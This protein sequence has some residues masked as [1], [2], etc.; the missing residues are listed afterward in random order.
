MR[1]RSSPC[2]PVISASAM[3]TAITPTITPSTEISEISEMNA[4]LRFAQQVAERDEQLERQ[5]L[6]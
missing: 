6:D 2:R 5:D 4:C 1:S 3:S